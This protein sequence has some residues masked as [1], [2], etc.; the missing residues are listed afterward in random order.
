MRRRGDGRQ[1]DLLSWEPERARVGFEASQVRAASLADRLCLGMKLALEECG[2]TREAVAEAMGAYLGKSFSKNML[3]AYVSPSRSTH[4]PSVVVLAAFV[5]ATGDYRVLGILPEAFSHIVVH[6]R[7]EA[8]VDVVLE[9][10][11]QRQAE[12]ELQRRQVA[13]QAKLRTVLGGAA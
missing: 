4:V 7:H 10:D 12:A 1:M 8:A 6:E 11:A 13:L 2:Q 9:A 5:S 3:D